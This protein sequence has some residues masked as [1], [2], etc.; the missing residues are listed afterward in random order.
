M[1]PGRPS[2]RQARLAQAPD[3]RL[4]ELLRFADD[5]PPSSDPWA[6]PGGRQPWRLRALGQAF[7]ISAVVYTGFRAFGYAAPYTLIAAVSAAAVLVRRAVAVVSESPSIRARDLV[8]SPHGIRQIT[9]GGWYEG[10]DGM[11]NAVRRWDRRL[12]WGATALER[13]NHTMPGRLGELVDE[14]LRQRHGITRASDPVRARSVLGEDLWTFLHQPV[15]HVPTPQ[16][17]AAVVGAMEKV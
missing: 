5:A 13:F 14:R 6:D 1:R 17:V 16:Q 10:G 11:L 15:K 4:D 7:A 8:R 2:R 12:D 9:P 3:A